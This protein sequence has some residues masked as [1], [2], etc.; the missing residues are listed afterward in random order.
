MILR[1]CYSDAIV[2]VKRVI[3]ER[4]SMAATKKTGRSASKKAVEKVGN[5]RK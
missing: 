4:E 5:A 2:T 1:R 3:I